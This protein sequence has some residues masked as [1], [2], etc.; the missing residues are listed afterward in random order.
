MEQSCS[1]FAD[2]ISS[3]SYVRKYHLQT[4][5]YFGN[6]YTELVKNKRS[7]TEVTETHITQNVKQHTHT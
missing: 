3:A 7:I 5:G 1:Q 2:Q 4:N 6:L